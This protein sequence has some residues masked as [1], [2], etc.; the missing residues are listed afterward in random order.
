M[1]TAIKAFLA[2]LVTMALFIGIGYGLVY[3]TNIIVPTWIGVAISVASYL[4]YNIFY[5]IFDDGG[6]D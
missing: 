1:K 4:L 2:T 6:D 5:S 3:Y